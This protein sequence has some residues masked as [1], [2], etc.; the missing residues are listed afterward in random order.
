MEAIKEQEKV[1]GRTYSPVNGRIT[2]YCTPEGVVHEC[3]EGYLTGEE[4][5]RLVKAD[6]T[7]YY[8]EHGLL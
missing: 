4:F 1:K 3:P 5:W 8:K 7:K 6:I 2:S